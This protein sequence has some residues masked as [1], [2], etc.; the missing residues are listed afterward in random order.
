[1]NV[2]ALSGKS[3][4]SA[5]LLGTGLRGKDGL[6]RGGTQVLILEGS[7]RGPLGAIHLS[8]VCFPCAP[9]PWGHEPTCPWKSCCRCA[10]RVPTAGCGLPLLSTCE[11]CLQVEESYSRSKSEGTK[12]GW[13]QG[14]SKD[15]E[16]PCAGPRALLASDLMAGVT[17][18]W[19]R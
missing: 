12:L 8:E 16:K 3:C 4:I 19:V 13:K 7:H 15:H 10:A 2:Q 14:L 18:S 17:H 1:M 6:T 9:V 11:L 5:C